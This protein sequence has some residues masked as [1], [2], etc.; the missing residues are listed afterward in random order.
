MNAI[1]EQSAISSP[2]ESRDT[3]YHISVVKASFPPHFWGKGEQVD[4]F[5]IH[6]GYAEARSLI[7][8]GSLAVLEEL[9]Y[10]ALHYTFKALESSVMESSSPTDIL[11]ELRLSNDLLQWRREQYEAGRVLPSKGEGLVQASD[12]VLRLLG[13][14]KWPQPLVTNGALFGAG[15]ANLLIGAYDSQTL[16]SNYCTDMVFYYEHSYHRVFP[17]FE[18]LLEMALND[19]IAMQTRAGAERR[20]A[21]QIGGKY[22]KGK[23]DL[24]VKYKARLSR[25][26][27][28]L[29]RRTAQIVFFLD[30]SLMGLAEEAIVRGFDPAAVMN[31]LV[32]SCPATD[33]VDVGS[34]FNNSEVMNSFLNAA[35]FMDTG[36]VTEDGLKRVYDAYS[37]AGARMFTERWADPGARMTACLYIWH[38]INNR[39]GFLRRALLGYPK[40]RK[41]PSEQ[42]EAD[43]D[44]AFDPDLR[45][46]GFSRPLKNSCNGGDPCDAVSR[47]VQ[48][49]HSGSTP[50]CDLLAKLWWCLITGPMEYVSKG[51]MDQDREDELATKLGET[52]AKVYSAGLIIELAW[53]V[54]HASHHAWQVNRLFEAAMFGSLLDDGGLEGKLDR[55]DHD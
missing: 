39:H 15:I 12:D 42:R 44:E 54:A 53:M 20:A 9:M 7:R 14:E 37:H 32:C 41:I 16:Y 31:D 40:A 5:P 34:D 29:D 4:S 52:I 33:V 22:I 28:K 23:V 47:L 55:R 1:D 36:I 11:I 17:E 48:Q 46:T 38:I 51:F 18:E 2:V 3:P 30:S 35:D 26:I 50:E 10:K 21:V 6:P 25:K 45:T 27:A 8:D 19:P 43:F 13:A 49:E 24:E